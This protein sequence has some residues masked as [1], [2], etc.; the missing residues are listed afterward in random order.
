MAIE[1]IRLPEVRRRTGLSISDIYR[2]MNAGK[3]PKSIPLGA[4]TVAWS[5]DEIEKW[6]M[7][8][9]ANRETARAKK[10]NPHFGRTAMAATA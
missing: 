4:R 5:G 1:L 6:V 3:F 10:R 9:I 7:D 2:L 8:I